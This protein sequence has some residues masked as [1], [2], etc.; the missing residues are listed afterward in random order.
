[1][2]LGIATGAFF[3]ESVEGFNLLGEAYIRLL[4]M[5]VL[6][7]ILVSLVGGL[8]RLDLRDAKRAGVIGGSLIL[9]LWS[10]TLASLLFLPLAYPDWTT[11]AFFSTSLLEP[12]VPFDA[13]GLYIPSNPFY[14]LANTVV[15][16]VVVFSVLLGASLIAVPNKDELLKGLGVLGDGLMRMASAVGKLAPIGIFAISAAAAGTLEVEELSKLQVYLWCYVAVWVVLAY[17]VLPIMVSAATPLSYREVVGAAQ[18]PMITA[19]ATGTV[20]VVLPMIVERCKELLAE[21]EIESDESESVVNLL[22]PTV[23]SFPSVGMLMGLGFVLFG[24]WYVGS[25]IGVLQYADFVG[26]GAF[27]AFGKMAVAIPFMLDYFAL[28]ADLFQLFLLGS[29]VTGRLTTAI[30]AVHGIVICLL[31]GAAIAGRLQIARLLR[32]AALGV[33]GIGIML[34]L[35]GF[36]LT[37][38]IPYEYAGEDEFISRGSV[39]ESA[40][41]SVLETP[42]PLPDIDRG[43]NRL[44]VIRE[45]GTIRVGYMP[46]TLPYAHRNNQGAVV[47]YDMDLI[48]ALARDLGVAVEIARIDLSDVVGWLDDGRLDIVIGGVPVMPDTALR[49]SYSG[50][51]IET[52]LGLVV[53]DHRR[54]EFS[55][56]ARIDGK[57]TLTLAVP[58]V[59]Y[60]V[61]MSRRLFPNAEIQPVQ[62]P[63]SFFT[64]NDADALVYTVEA[65]AAWALIYPEFQ[66]VVPKDVVV[67]VPLS[68]A[69]PRGE[70]ELT[71]Y[72]NTWLELTKASGL[73]DKLYRYWFLGMDPRRAAPRWS[74]LRNVLGVG[75]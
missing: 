62:S 71:R 53:R 2:A 23:Y 58:D 48:H 40:S 30:A 50:V 55:D 44:D 12:A 47:G 56:K 36:V 38:A 5:T 28:P 17:A 70:V 74:I 39:M 61:A 64:N 43:N 13:L 49:I 26:V 68:F 63:R 51:Y 3:G 15:P 57:K 52:T 9:L 69:L 34:M 41:A 72:V 10:V 66:A 22:A 73:S 29:V 37:E 16:A 75:Q 42:E 20:L 54:D 59:P 27:V 35:L 6:P 46:D 18:V 60:Y 8:G 31:G 21:H 19:L 7:Y 11:S 33:V 45:R 24:A 1:M 14:S 25:P 4:Q 65:G 32:A 67:R